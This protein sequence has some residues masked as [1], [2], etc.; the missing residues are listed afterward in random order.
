MPCDAASVSPAAALLG[1]SNVM[2]I[3]CIH[4]G[5]ASTAKGPRFS[6]AGNLGAYAPTTV[7]AWQR[8]HESR[9]SV[10]GYVR[11]SDKEFLCRIVG[12]AENGPSNNGSWVG[13]KAPGSNREHRTPAMYP[14]VAAGLGAF[15]SVPP[16]QR[17]LRQC[18]VL[19]SA[20]D[21]RLSGAWRPFEPLLRVG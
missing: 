20:P 5:H 12:V 10:G 21:S 14:P 15:S 16:R 11:E 2:A 19:S 8:A 17:E 4:R 6:P 3:Y 1:L 13:F 7:T 9:T 18:V